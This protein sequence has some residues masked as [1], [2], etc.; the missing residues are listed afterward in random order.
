MIVNRLILCYSEIGFSVAWS[1]ISVNQLKG[2]FGV[3]IFDIKEFSVHDGPGIRTTV[4]FKGCPLDC[5]WCHNPE[6]KLSTPQMMRTPRGERLVGKR[7]SPEELAAYLNRQASILRANEGGITLSGGEPLMQT[8]FIHATLDLL[9]NIHIL[10]DTSGF[11]NPETFS[12]L[13]TRCNLV[14]FDLKLIDSD[15]HKKYTGQW[16]DSI[17]QNL[18]LLS[19]SGV[20]FVIRVPLVPTITD[21]DSNLLAIANTI[22][23]LPGLLRVDLLPYNRLAGAKYPLLGLEYALR[24]L[25]QNQHPVHIRTDFFSERGIEVICQ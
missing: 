21:T 5:V 10:L 22:Q 15:L 2:F 6:G 4:F 24:W 7:Y 18:Q 20:P 3:V 19:Q 8:A 9:Q 23:G 14:Y 25:D 16:N 17:L 11:A 1:H 12:R 13:V